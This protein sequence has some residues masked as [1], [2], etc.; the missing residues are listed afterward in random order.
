MRRVLIVVILVVAAAALGMW[1]SHG[2]I[3]QG[4]SKAVGMSSDDSQGEVRQ[5]IRK[6]FE[7]QPG[8]R[9][10]V[11]GIN[12]AVEIQTSDT[13]TADVYALRT[14]NS[15]EALNRREF[16]IEQTANGLLVRA[17]KSRNLGFWERLWGLGHNPNEQVTIK[18]PRQI[19]L[20]I[21]GVNGRVTSGDI[22]GPL[23]VKG[24]N[25]GVELGQVTESAEISGIN[26][27]IS[28]GF[29]QLGDRGARVSGVNG[30]IELRFAST[31]NADL[32]AKGM[33]GSVHSEIPEVAV[34]K[35]DHGSR[36]SARI[37]NGGAPITIS[38]INGNVRLT[39]A[40]SVAGPTVT[41][42]KSTTAPASE[43]KTS[44]AKDK[45]SEN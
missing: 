27:N 40:T 9:V 42:K 38:G 1:R 41:E 34:D 14:A 17:Q 25:G 18:A 4:L 15:S 21:K 44:A 5:E 19:A 26:G 12:G 2:G 32:T 11:Q 30:N 35:N 33:N 10:D 36:Y 37:G 8:A 45:K 22:D 39:H 31:V 29:K 23:E 28:V 43:A 7:M 20:S 16:I 3:R 24:I 13:K 6:S